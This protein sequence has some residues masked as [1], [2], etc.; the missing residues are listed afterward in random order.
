M[1]GDGIEYIYLVTPAEINGSTTT[2]S[3]VK[4]FMV[5]TYSLDGDYQKDEFCFNDE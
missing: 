5:P 2:S 1:D 3:H 4:E